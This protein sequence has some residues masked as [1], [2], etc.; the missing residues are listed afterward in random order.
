MAAYGS[1]RKVTYFDQTRCCIAA[2]TEPVQRASTLDKRVRHAPKL[3]SAR[4]IEHT[5]VSSAENTKSTRHRDRAGRYEWREAD[6]DMSM[7]EWNAT[8]K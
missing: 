6:I 8:F 7:R 5:E 2:D 3:F 1:E 4:S